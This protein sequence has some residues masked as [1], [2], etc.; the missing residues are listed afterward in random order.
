M[1]PLINWVETGV[2]PQRIDA[3]LM[4]EGKVARTRPLC[5]YPEVARYNGSG[6]IDETANFTCRYP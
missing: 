6:S 2:A 3:A 4:D 1:T 5:P